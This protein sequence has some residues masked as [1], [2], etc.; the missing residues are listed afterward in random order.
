MLSRMRIGIEQPLSRAQ[1]SRTRIEAMLAYLGIRPVV[2]RQRPRW[3][4]IPPVIA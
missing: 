1:G 2:R 4:Y 3:V